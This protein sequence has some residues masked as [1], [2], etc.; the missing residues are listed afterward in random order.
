MKT[1]NAS[2]THKTV[3]RTPERNTINHPKTVAQVKHPNGFVL[4]FFNRQTKIMKC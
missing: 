1:L 2:I 3:Y 4:L